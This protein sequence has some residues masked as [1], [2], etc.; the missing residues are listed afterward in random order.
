MRKLLLF[1]DLDATLLDHATYSFEAAVP[2]LDRLAAL[3]WPVILNTSKT[4]AEVQL[5][6]KRLNNHEAYIVE[7]GSAVVPG[8]IADADAIAATSP[9]TT[10]A[11]DPEAAERTIGTQEVHILGA[12][13][14]EIVQ[15]LKALREQHGYRFI[16]FADLS[17][18]EVSGL[19]GLPHEQ[20]A[21]ARARHASEPL[22]WQ[23][24]D[25]AL[26]Q[27][28]DQVRAEGFQVTL[29]GRFVHVMG[30]TDKG[31]A[32]RWLKTRYLEANPGSEYTVVALGDSPNDLPMLNM[33]DIA[34]AIPHPNKPEM[35][36]D[37]PRVIRPKQKG[38]A[39]WAEAILPLIDEFASSD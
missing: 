22:F 1:T 13:R 27:L 5:W 14:G 25:A 32:A 9:G 8:E 17:S 33:A 20:A 23:D 19:T 38:P 35:Q 36:V 15:A 3:G 24:S 28:T 26:T 34:V 39:G 10:E 6:R 2:A 37:A 16:G 12:P 21:L 11:P 7:N 18:E 31:R 30:Q 4:A 29:G